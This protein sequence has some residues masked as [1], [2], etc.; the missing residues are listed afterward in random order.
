MGPN[1]VTV[2]PVSSNDPQIK[3][4]R[5]TYSP[6]LGDVENLKE[7]SGNLLVEVEEE[8]KGVASGES[9]QL[10]IQGQHSPLLTLTETSENVQKKIIFQTK[11]N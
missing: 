4:F 5:V 1:L 6:L 10:S 2:S 7:I 9:V 3:I 8:T 11:K